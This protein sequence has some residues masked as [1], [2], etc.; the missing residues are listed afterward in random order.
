MEC[1]MKEAVRTILQHIGEN[2]DREGLQ[3]TPK[4]VEAAWSELTAGYQQ[5]PE[6][7]LST[8]FEGED[9]DE[10]VVVKNIEFHS[11]CEHHMMPFIGK[12][13][14][15]YLPEDRVVGLSKIPRLVHCF[16]RRLQIQERLT[17]EISSTLHSI[18]KTKGVGVV[19]EA[20]HLCLSCRG[21]K[22]QGSTMITSSL[23]GVFRKP[24]VRAEFLS[25]VR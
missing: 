2:P 13:H 14:V 20:S 5:R 3:D 1:S 11:M 23:L 24:E 10:M 16:A 8:T 25:L 6:E 4:R 12:A 17:G 9:Y 21:I 7:I 15:A 18:L 22:Q 19:I